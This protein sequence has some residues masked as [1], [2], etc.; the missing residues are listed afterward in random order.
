M[1]DNK[2]VEIDFNTAMLYGLW[3]VYWDIANPLTVQTFDE[4]VHH[5]KDIFR[6][7]RIDTS[8]LGDIL[9]KECFT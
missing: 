1:S 7:P 6:P 2:L 3:R 5:M 9:G 8:E 4:A